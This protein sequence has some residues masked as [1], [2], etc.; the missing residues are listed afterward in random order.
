[1]LGYANLEDALTCDWQWN[2]QRNSS[3]CYP[4]RLQLLLPWWLSTGGLWGRMVCG[5]AWIHRR[6]VPVLCPPLSLQHHRYKHAHGTR[7]GE[8][9]PEST[10]NWNHIFYLHKPIYWSACSKWS[11]DRCILIH[12][13]SVSAQQKD[14]ICLRLWEIG[15]GIFFSF[16]KAWSVCTSLT[17]KGHWSFLFFIC[18]C[19]LLLQGATHVFALRAMFMSVSVCP[20]VA[21][22]QM[23]CFFFAA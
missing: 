14:H 13:S 7:N 23:F 21:Y 19:T 1:M 4:Y 6:L 12:L 8:L 17:S 20:S 22:P 2:L 16:C 15:L 3:Q 18:T 10:H 11:C 5:W 9:E